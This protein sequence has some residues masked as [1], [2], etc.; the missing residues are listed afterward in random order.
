MLGFIFRGDDKA[1][2]ET[3]LHFLETNMLK[4]GKMTSCLGLVLKCVSKG[5]KKKTDKSQQSKIL[6]G[7]GDAHTRMA[8]LLTMT[9][10]NFH[11]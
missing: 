3:S 11:N 2:L 4:Y 9:Y 7:V 1:I 10:S 5:K 6:T 8:F